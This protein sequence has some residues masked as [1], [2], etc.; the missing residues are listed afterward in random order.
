MSDITVVIPVFNEGE[1]FRNTLQSIRDTSPPSAV[2]IVCVDD[3]STDGL[4]Y[5]EWSKHFGAR[6]LR[7]R[8]RAGTGPS[9]ELGIFE[10]KTRF[11]ITTDSHMR[12]GSDGWYRKICDEI[13]AEPNAAYCTMCTK[14]DVDDSGELVYGDDYFGGDIKLVTGDVGNGTEIIEAKW[15]T[16]DDPEAGPEIP[17]ILGAN[18]A[19]DKDFFFR[20]KGFNGMR[21][22]GFEETYM[23][24][25]AWLSGA[26]CRLIRDVSIGHIF[27][28]ASPYT[29]Q[30]WNLYYNKMFIARTI[31]PPN[32]AEL[33]IDKLPRDWNF[34]TADSEMQK[35]SLYVSAMRDYY[36][37]IFVRDV[38]WLRDRLGIG[39]E[40]EVDE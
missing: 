34:I 20:M 28:E 22:W 25:K 38:D 9:R 40:E 23:S 13:A 8:H 37:S 36:R 1:E 4:P 3:G 27:R 31:F 33:L 6:C 21:M 16:T 18:Y 32:Y 14:I 26:S 5:E 24:L 19:F 2:D 29:T 17:C 39:M 12:F 11:V 7:N 30:V 15:R 10:S 35:A